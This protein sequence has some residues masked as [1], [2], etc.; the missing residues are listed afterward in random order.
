M[1]A[2]LVERFLPYS[3]SKVEPERESKEEHQPI[4]EVILIHIERFVGIN[5]L[6]EAKC[7]L[8]LENEVPNKFN[9]V[10]SSNY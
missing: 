10:P 1:E 6:R 3:D 7:G 9:Q 5:I 2:V 4:N 8:V